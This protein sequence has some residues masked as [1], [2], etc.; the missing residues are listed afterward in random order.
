VVAIGY[1]EHRSTN[2]LTC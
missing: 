1:E 2:P